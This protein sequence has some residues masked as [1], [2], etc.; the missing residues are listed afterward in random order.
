M[1]SKII[2]A[3]DKEEEIARWQNPITTEIFAALLDLGAKSATDSL[4]AVV[5]DWFTFI[6][7]TGLRCAEYAQK[8]Q[9]SVDE[10]KYPSGKRVVKAFL[11]TD[12]KFYNQK[13]NV[14]HVHPLNNEIRTFP[15]KM[16]V[17]YQIQKNRQNGQS[18]TLVSM[19]TTRT[20]VRF[21]PPTE[22]SCKPNASGSL[23]HSQWP[24]LSINMAILNT[25]PVTRS[26]MYC[27]PLLEW[28]TQIFL[29]TRLKDSPR[30]QGKFGP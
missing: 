1:C 22:S 3:R 13:G 12:W 4:E 18:I 10:H 26:Q 2:L 6:R 16:K 5:A 28:F 7:I 21:V 24:F 19:M 25:L 27:A 15:K 23:T 14:M 8:M 17:T 29:K 30:I 11:L 20:F 9:I